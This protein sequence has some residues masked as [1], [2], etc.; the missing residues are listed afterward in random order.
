ML[1]EPPLTR[2]CGQ[3]TGTAL[4]FVQEEKSQCHPDK[5]FRRKV[6]E[7]K[8]HCPNKSLGCEWAR[9]LSDLD[10]HLEETCP[11]RVIKCEFNYAGCEVECQ[12]Q[13]MQSHL[14]ENVKVHLNKVSQHTITLQ[15]KTEQQQSIIELQQRQIAVLTSAQAQDVLKPLALF[16]PPPDIVMTDIE[17]HR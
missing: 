1:W 7:L 17:K 16:V 14:E 5:Y 12:R 4:S 9:E 15:R 11:M 10:K 6:N 2:G 13:H 8:V 3:A